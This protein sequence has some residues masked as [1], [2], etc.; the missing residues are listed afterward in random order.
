M[1]KTLRGELAARLRRLDLLLVL[2]AY[3]LHPSIIHHF[4]NCTGPV[5]KTT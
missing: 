3:Q 1:L 4:E 2:Y 5:L